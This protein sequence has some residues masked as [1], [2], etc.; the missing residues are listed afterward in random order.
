MVFVSPDTQLTLTT[1]LIRNHFY[2]SWSPTH[3]P[4][5]AFRKVTAIIIHITSRRLVCIV[6]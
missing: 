1:V 4:P 6:F 3:I 5:S 2:E